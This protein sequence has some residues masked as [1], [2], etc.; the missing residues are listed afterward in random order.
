MIREALEDQPP[1]ALTGARSARVPIE[2]GLVAAVVLL[3]VVL[4]GWPG[5]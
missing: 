3:A 1:P 2:A 4:A 5:R